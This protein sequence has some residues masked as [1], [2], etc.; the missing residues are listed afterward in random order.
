VYNTVGDGAGSSVP[1]SGR[2]FPPGF[3]PF[4]HLREG[5]VAKMGS[6]GLETETEVKLA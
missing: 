4:L 2:S 6:V 5:S 3:E 1:T